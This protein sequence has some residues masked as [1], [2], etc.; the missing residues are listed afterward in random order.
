MYLVFSHPRIE[1]VISDITAC[2]KVGAVA[3]AIAVIVAA[4]GGASG[5][6]GHVSLAAFQ[7]AFYACMYSKGISWA[8]EI[9]IDLKT[10]NKSCGNW[11][12]L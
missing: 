9:G 1:T 6:I 8:S 12:G 10:E 2:C 7:A 4:V 3:S 5:A 11:H